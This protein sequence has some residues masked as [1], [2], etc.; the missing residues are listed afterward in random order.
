MCVCVCKLMFMC[1]DGLPLPHIVN[2]TGSQQCQLSKEMVSYWSI[3]FDVKCGPCEVQMGVLG[4][5]LAHRSQFQQ[6]CEREA[7]A[8]RLLKSSGEVKGVDL[9][10]ILVSIFMNIEEFRSV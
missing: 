10:A 8:R 9:G 7:V 5:I 6:Q 3:D 2:D 1:V 4:E